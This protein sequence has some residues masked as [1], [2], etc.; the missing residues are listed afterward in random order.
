MSKPCKDCKQSIFNNQDS[1]IPEPLC[2]GD[3][4]EDVNCN[5][6]VTYSDCV[7]VNAALDCFDTEVGDSLT[8]VLQ[9]ANEKCKQGGSS[10][11]C[12]VKVSSNDTCCAYLETKITS[13]D[14]DISIPDGTSCKALVISEKCRTWID[15]RPTDSLSGSFQ[16]GWTNA[17][18][19]GLNVQICQHSSIKG[20]TVKLRGSVVKQSWAGGIPLE[21]FTLPVGKRPPVIRWFHGSMDTSGYGLQIAT[22]LI[23]P[24]G[25]V[26]ISSNQLLSSVGVST[27]LDGIEFELN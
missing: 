17:D 18:P 5:G 24:N 14:L 20:C 22:F 8:S 27:S 11:N 10:S 2:Q 13:S 9:A 12:K 4:P 26:T 21:I 6:E 3:C 23:N 15:V 25:A 16:N 7:T 1:S 19:S